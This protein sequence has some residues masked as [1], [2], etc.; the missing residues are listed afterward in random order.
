MSWSARGLPSSLPRLDRIALR[1]AAI[2]SRTAPGPVAAIVRRRIRAETRGVVI[3]AADPAFARHVAASDDGGVRPQRQP[4][5][6]GD[7]RRRRGRRSP[8]RPVRA[9]PPARRRLRVGEDLGAVR[10][11]RR[12]RLRARGRPDRRAPPRPSTTSPQRRRPPVFVNLDMEEY[13]DLAPDR[14][15]LPRACSTSRAYRDLR[16]GIV[17]AGVPAR[18]PRRRS[19]T[20]SRGS[21]Q[22]RDDGGAPVKVRLVKGANLAM[23]RRR[24]RAARLDARR[25]TRPRPTST[26]ATSACSTGCST[27]AADGGLQRRRRQ[28][29][30]VRRGVGARTRSAGAGSR[31]S[32]SSRCSRAWRRRR[33]AR[34]ATRPDALLLY[35]PVVDATTTSPRAS[36]TSPAASTRTPAPENFLRALFTIAP[37]LA[38]VGRPSGAASSSPSPSAATCRPTPR[39]VQDRGTEHRTFDPDAPFANEPDTDFTQRGQPGAGSP[40]P[41]RRSPGAARRRS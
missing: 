8:R 17:A 18:H 35:T 23:E 22:R 25:P 12:A 24:R 33:R 2:G 26:P 11:P 39:R 6:R 16:A 28:P 1:L 37:G 13:R 5:R 30:P 36:P 41:R 20:S 19:T 15:R 40:P 21:P 3:P 10:R 27:R 29:Q 31:P 7:P 38:G 4:A 32:P 9:D 14:R 34:R